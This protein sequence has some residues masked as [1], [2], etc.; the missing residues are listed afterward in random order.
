MRVGTLPWLLCHEWRLWKRD[1]RGLAYFL[2]GTKW[3]FG[4]FAI[5]LLFCI[6][7]I[8]LATFNDYSSQ[9][10]Q[11]FQN[12]FSQ[13]S[14]LAFWRS[15]GLISLF[16]VLGPLN[17]LD[18]IYRFS[19]KP[20]AF[21]LPASS[22]VKPQALFSVE[23]CKL[24][25]EL[26]SGFGVTLPISICVAVLIQSVQPVIGLAIVELQL[27][28][29][30]PTLTLWF[31]VLALRLGI[32]RT[33]RAFKLSL[34]FVFW[35]CAI[36][37]VVAMYCVDWAIVNEQQLEQLLQH[38]VVNNFWWGR[39]SWLWLPARA[40]LLE[41]QAIALMTLLTVGVAG[42]TYKFLPTTTL[43]AA[44]QQFQPQQ[45]KSTAPKRSKRP[46]Q[47]VSG[48]TRSIVL[49][50]WRSLQWRSLLF[51]IW[52]I[53]AFLLLAIAV[54]AF[55]PQD[56]QQLPSPSVLMMGLTV[57]SG[58][59]LSSTLTRR[60]IAQDEAMEWLT[61]VPV[62][63]QTLRQS[64]FLAILSLIWVALSPTIILVP[65]FGGSVWIT[66]FV[67]L[68]T[69]VSQTLLSYWNAIPID[70]KAIGDLKD[71]SLFY[72]DDL[73]MWLGAA[74]MFLWIACGFLLASDQWPYGILALGLELAVMSIAYRRYRKLGESLI[75]Y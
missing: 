75:P 58:A 13:N 23:Y 46:K 35:G 44:L 15:V 74:S 26:L 40:L 41:P 60:C 56:V 62:R 64:K 25:I 61:T 36:T 14:D 65:F 69:P 5:A 10:L 68:G 33:L 42:V 34:G 55:G 24:L 17:V 7:W 4:G 28:V 57:L 22:P 73:L 37:F 21:I 30:M 19:R 16:S 18:Y 11:T 66:A 31:L 12:D 53:L 51:A 48:I 20:A 43:I 1:P 59:L 27:T 72:R 63:S 39:A 52:R 47:F 67:V 9:G 45:K 38:Y 32:K 50:E 70:R 54:V 3:V 71:T 6:G 29:L 8:Y 49:K 2:D